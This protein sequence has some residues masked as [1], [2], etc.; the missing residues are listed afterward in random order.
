MS[1]T[2]DRSAAVLSHILEKLKNWIPPTGLKEY[3]PHALETDIIITTAPKAGTTLTQYM[4]YLIVNE[5]GKAQGTDFENIDFISP[6]L[7]YHDIMKIPLPSPEDYCP[8]ILKSHSIRKQ[9]TKLKLTNARHIVVIR[10]P[11]DNPSSVFNM[12][13]ASM[14]AD[15]TAD[16]DALSD[17]N[18]R[19]EVLNLFAK[20]TLLDA[21]LEIDGKVYDRK[22]PSGW[23]GHVKTWCFPEIPKNVFVLFYEDMVA[24]LPAA[25]ERISKFMGFSLNAEQVQ[26]IAGMCTREKMAGDPRFDNI[27]AGTF[28]MDPSKLKRVIKDPLQDF[29]KY[30]LDNDVVSGINE[31][32]KEEFGV[33]SYDGLREL[34]SKKQE[35]IS[36][37]QEGGSSV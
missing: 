31:R 34:I 16:T 7:E 26:K 1:S 17:E 12:L 6:W 32:L 5:C 21:P 22:N 30:K 3:K 24:D 20:R 11:L 29:K 15:Y 4:S 37:S 27:H 9:F 18:V 19:K 35:K 10:S 33:D 23:F 13:F 28:G 25:V 36:E 2:S 14:V 8:R